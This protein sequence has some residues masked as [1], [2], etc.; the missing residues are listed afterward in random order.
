MEKKDI[1]FIVVM[2]AAVALSLYQRY[3]RKKKGL[4]GT[5]GNKFEEKKGLSGQPDDYEPYSKGKS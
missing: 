5:A 1:I 2:I 4:T 3:V